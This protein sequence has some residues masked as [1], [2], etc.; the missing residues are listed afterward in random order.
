MSAPS[1]RRNSKLAFALMVPVVPATGLGITVQ[2]IE[3]QVAGSDDDSPAWD[4]LDYSDWSV[5]DR[6]WQVQQTNRQSR[7][8]NYDN[9][10]FTVGTGSSEPTDFVVAEA[11]SNCWRKPLGRTKAR[12][13]ENVDRVR[14]QLRSFD[15]SQ[16]T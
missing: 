13:I 5:L 1:E 7:R 14:E 2:Q 11:E 12:I 10:Y 16:T 3:H 15:P 8:F 6:L 9:I 4:R